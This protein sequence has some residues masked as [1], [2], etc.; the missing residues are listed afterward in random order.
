MQTRVQSITHSRDPAWNWAP[1]RSRG[2]G[3]SAILMAL[4]SIAVLSIAA[5]TLF[6]ALSPRCETAWRSA[7]WQ[8]STLAAESALDMAV[9]EL[10]RV[11]PAV[12][13]Y[14][15]DA[16]SGWTSSTGVLPLVRG[17]LPGVT[18]SLTPPPLIHGGEG[19]TTEQ[20]TV[21]VDV[22]V[23]LVDLAGHQWFRIRATG[24]T[25]MPTMRRAGNS[26]LD[27]HLRKL[28]LVW[29]PAT[30]A[31]VG[32]PK[33]SRTFELTVRPVL[34]FEAALLTQGS[35]HISNPN[36]YIDSFNSTDPLK[37]TGGQYDS[38]KRQQNAN[39]DTD[40]SDFQFAGTIYGNAGTNGGN[41][42]KS[43]QITG[44]VDNNFYQPLAPIQPPNWSSVSPA[45]PTVAAPVT[46]SGGLVAAPAQYKFNAITSTLRVTAG[47]TGLQTE[48]E[49]WV[50]G[51]ITGSIVL[52][53]NVHAKIYVAGNVNVKASDLNNQSYRAAKL[54]IYGIQPPANQSQSIAISLGS[55]LYAAIYAPGHSIQFTGNG[56]VIGSIVANS[57]SAS[58]KLQ[59]HYDEAL[60]S[61]AGL[62]VDY[63]VASWIE[64]IR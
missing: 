25:F 54:E 44:N 36:G 10:R 29:D 52:D 49:I 23:G 15:P 62:V 8:E 4:L 34:P 30:G 19:N 51:D 5:G 26:K 37:S 27:N 35:I 32:Q 40:G 24:T 21:S 33:V 14:P 3:G 18:L 64:D 1:A 9:A 43:S 61:Q 53:P 48:V 58:G 56:D 6:L 16:W 38:A 13:A 59:L 41:L 50:T 60:A 57:F 63:K 47:L 17:I 7:S 28:S 45:P 22:P 12:K 55:D 2:A 31:K 42:Q 11:Q 39:V 46:I 20:G